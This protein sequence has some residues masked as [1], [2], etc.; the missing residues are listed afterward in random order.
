MD[1][2]LDTV[3]TLLLKHL[4]RRT[5][6][7]NTIYPL[8]VPNSRNRATNVI[9]RARAS[10]STE[11]AQQ[12]TVT[13][14]SIR[15]TSSNANNCIDGNAETDNIDESNIIDITADASLYTLIPLNRTN[16]NRSTNSASNRSGHGNGGSSPI[17]STLNQETGR[18]I[19]A[20]V[21]IQEAQLMS[22]NNNYTPH[23]TI[24]ASYRSQNESFPNVPY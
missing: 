16:S 1:V 15:I 14:N 9:A 21:V 3:N 23:Y 6:L 2:I 12:L 20:H 24:S 4:E 5:D 8:L 11:G 10:T 7:N 22:S 17:V 19:G 13:S 18:D